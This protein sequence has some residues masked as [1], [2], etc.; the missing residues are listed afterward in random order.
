LQVDD[1]DTQLEAE[2]DG[3]HVAEAL[4]ALGA[5][6]LTEDAY[7]R[8]GVPDEVLNFM[9][10]HID[11]LLGPH[12]TRVAGAFAHQRVGAGGDLASLGRDRGALLDL[13]ALIEDKRRRGFEWQWSADHPAYP[14]G[15]AY[16]PEALLVMAEYGVEDPVWDRPRGGGGPVSLRELNVSSSLVQRLR[17]WNKTYERSALPDAGWASPE[18]YSAWAQQGLILARELQHELPDVNVRYFHTDDDRP[19]HSF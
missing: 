8:G 18:A 5:W 7:E 10:D 2:A 4:D 15:E 17:A 19:L 16:R 9:Q 3:R 13:L 12:A 11:R 6:L 14:A 1:D